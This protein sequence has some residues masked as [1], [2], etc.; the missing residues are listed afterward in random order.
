MAYVRGDRGCFDRWAREAGASWSASAVEPFFARAGH[1]LAITDTNDPNAAHLAFLAAARELGYAAEYYRKNIRN[2][3]R[4]SAAHAFLLPALARPTLAVSPNTL[5]RRIVCT[6][7]R[8][9]AVEV[10][11]DGR[12]EQIRATREIVLSAGAIESPKL[13]L[14]SGVGPADALEAHGI[15]VVADSP[16]VGSNLQDHPRV[17]L[18]WKS[19]KPLA[20]SSTSAGLFVRSGGASGPPSQIPDLQFYVGRGLDVVDDFITLTVAL[21]QPKSRGTVTLRSTDPTSHPVIRANYFADASD[22]DALVDGVRLAR[23]LAS[24][25]AYAELRGDP[26]APSATVQTPNALRAW[27][28]ET[29]D[30]I[31]HPAGTCRM[32]LDATAVVDAELLVRGVDGL[33]IADASIMPTVMNSQ[34]HAACLMIAEK[35]A[36]HII[37]GTTSTRFRG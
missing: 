30:T 28:R 20:P 35:A 26:V 27:I 14:L 2:G 24:S 11:R 7:G 10:V 4:H 21:A 17:S 31:F 8:A 37:S 13:L 1:D 33:R 15:S 19:L 9:T 3:R 5:V 18:R 6:R 16:S 32:G 34:T 12:V 29:A 25:R 22:L 23:A 36:A